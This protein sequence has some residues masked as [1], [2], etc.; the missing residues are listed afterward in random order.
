[1]VAPAAGVARPAL[2]ILAPARANVPEA[3]GEEP[4]LQRGLVGYWRFDD[5]RGSAL[6]HDLSAGGHDCVLHG[7]DPER[8]WVKGAFGGAIRLG[9]RT[10]LECPQPAASVPALELSIA[11]WTK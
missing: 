10:W 9:P 11:A 6:A 1:S 7:L 2:R 5:G 4:A 3:G 8:A